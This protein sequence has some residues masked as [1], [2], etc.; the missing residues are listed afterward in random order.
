MAQTVELY[1][2]D[3]GTGGPLPVVFLHSS[4]G[5]ASQWSAQLEH[6]R[7][8]RRAVALEW[9]GHGRSGSPADG[10]YSFPA[11]AAD[12][13]EAVDRL[14][15]ERFVLVGHSG[16]G[17]VALEYAADR[18][19]RVAGLLLADPAG[20]ARQVPSEQME[21]LLLGLASDAYAQTIGKYWGFL[22]TGS[23]AMV[24][25]RVMADLWST[26]KEAVVGFFRA[27]RAYDPL[28]ALRRY[29]GPK[30]SVITLVND[31]P[32]GL[33]NLSADLPHTIFTGTGHWLQMDK[34]DEFNRILDEFLAHIEGKQPD[35]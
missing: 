30:L 34:P 17:L 14:G 2:D 13:D 29:V 12:V 7:P 28:P 23:D 1:A 9:R 20:D 5:N 31:A 6:L 3:G 16:G 32:F 11:V 19:E 21:P 35:R 8:R 10:D 4:A 24:R 22:L 25:E 27:H 18:Q 15:I 33:H 26:P